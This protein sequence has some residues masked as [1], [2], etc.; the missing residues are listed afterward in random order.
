MFRR[1]A[2]A[3]PAATL[4]LTLG[5]VIPFVAGAIA[6]FVL[7]DEI[8]RQAA[9]QLALLAYTAMILSFLGGVRWGVEIAHPS[10]QSPRFFILAVS[11]IGAL[12]GWALVLQ[13]VLVGLAPWLFLA[14]AGLIVLHWAWDVIGARDTPAWYDGLRTLGTIGATAALLAAYLVL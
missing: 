4:V 13:A 2:F 9:A 11:V 12:A 6:L 10:G 5:G 3:M 14:A 1:G 7:R 8:A